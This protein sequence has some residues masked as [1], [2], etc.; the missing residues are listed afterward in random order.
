M[1]LDTTHTNLRPAY[2]E[3]SIKMETSHLRQRRMRPINQAMKHI[4]IKTLMAKIIVAVQ[5]FSG[6]AHAQDA[7]PPQDCG[8]ATGRPRTAMDESMQAYRAQYGAALKTKYGPSGKLRQE[9]EV[10]QK[11]MC[12]LLLPRIT[13]KHWRNKNK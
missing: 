10:A 9:I 11:W 3:N 13:R 1:Q 6:V 2:A 4:S 5:G 7:V 8:D 12:L